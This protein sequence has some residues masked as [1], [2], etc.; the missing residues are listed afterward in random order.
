VDIL[1]GPFKGLFAR[2]VVVIDENGK[3]IYNQLVPEIA[4]EPDYDAAL[5][6]L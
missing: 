1:D 5:A 6:V 4:D 3:V 2:S